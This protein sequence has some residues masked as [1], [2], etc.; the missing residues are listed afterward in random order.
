MSNTWNRF[1]W[2]RFL[3]KSI[4]RQDTFEIL[5]RPSKYFGSRLFIETRGRSGRKISSKPISTLWELK[6]ISL[7]NIAGFS[8]RFPSQIQGF[9]HLSQ[10]N[11]L[12]MTRSTTFDVHSYCLE[13]QKSIFNIPNIIKLSLF[14][15]PIPLLFS[16][17]WGDLVFSQELLCISC[18]MWH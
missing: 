16:P 2:R 11:F 18:F 1:S 9:S 10:A 5:R 4:K 8:R 17:Q 15:H 3:H 12:F 6:S 13:T 7:I 14:K